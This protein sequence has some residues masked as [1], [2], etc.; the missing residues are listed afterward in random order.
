MKFTVT[1]THN[2]LSGKT[3]R[4]TF[5]SEQQAK[6]A[7]KELM[8]YVDSNPKHWEVAIEANG[9]SAPW[10]C[11]SFYLYADVPLPIDWIEL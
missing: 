10:I 11:D 9:N 8:D 4:L 2:D 6:F 1:A 7:I 3:Y 5:A